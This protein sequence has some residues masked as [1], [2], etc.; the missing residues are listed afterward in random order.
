MASNQRQRYEPVSTSEPPSPP[1]VPVTLT[2]SP[3][4]DGAALYSPPPPYE[5]S[6]EQDTIADSDLPPSYDIAAKLPTYEE[7]ERV[8]EQYTDLVERNALLI[9]GGIEVSLGNDW[10]FLICFI[11][12]FVF[13]WLGFFAAYCMTKTVAGRYGAISGFGLSVVKWVLILK[14]AASDE[15]IVIHSWI[16]WLFKYL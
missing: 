6:T 13:N 9:D 11:I 7:A 16:W 14:N 1:P 4:P 5:P 10:L 8:K 12:S 2:I 3:P 15:V